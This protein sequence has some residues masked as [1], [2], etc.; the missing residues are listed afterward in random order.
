M[1]RRSPPRSSA[2]SH[3][4]SLAF[5]AMVGCNDSNFPRNNG[6][7]MK[8]ATCFLCF[9]FSSSAIFAWPVEFGI[10]GGVPLATLFAPLATNRFDGSSGGT[11][12]QNYSTNLNRYT[13]GPM[14]EMALP[15]RLSIELGAFYKHF[16]YNHDTE[17]TGIF[18]DFRVR[19]QRVSVSRWEFPLLLKYQP[20]KRPGLY[21]AAGPSLNYISTTKQRLESIT[22]YV[23]GSTRT[24]ISRE[25]TSSSDKP[26]DLMRRCTGGIAT[27]L[28]AKFRI[29]KVLVSPEFRYTRW[30]NPNFMTL[31][32]VSHTGPSTLAL[33]SRLD[34][35][36]FLV[37]IGF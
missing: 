8:C 11:I 26:V 35:V 9:L 1:C 7:N 29:H 20:L 21:I 14:V 22:E 37:G 25:I 28:G 3:D 18:G 23:S 24:V 13:V 2:P 32:S 6:A 36:D 33:K 19:H 12:K 34:Q 17:T 16:I 10:K 5:A 15:R 4:K 31:Y 30:L 27:S